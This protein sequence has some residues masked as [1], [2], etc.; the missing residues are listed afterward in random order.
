MH[1]AS[2]KVHEFFHLEI[3]ICEMKKNSWTNKVVPDVKLN[4]VRIITKFSFLQKKFR[5][6]E[7]VAKIVYGIL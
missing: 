5:V 4:F 3:H 2:S 6:F 7:L 1:Y